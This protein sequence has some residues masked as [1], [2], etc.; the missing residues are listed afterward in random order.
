MSDILFGDVMSEQSNVKISC[1]LTLY[2]A[3]S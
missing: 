2:F 1:D 3:M